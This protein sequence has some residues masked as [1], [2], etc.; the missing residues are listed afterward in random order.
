MGLCQ[1]LAGLVVIENQDSC[2]APSS[3]R[4]RALQN[5]SLSWFRAAHRCNVAR[6]RVLARLSPWI[7]QGPDGHPILKTQ[8]GVRMSV[9]GTFL[10]SE[11]RAGSAAVSSWRARPRLLRYFHVLISSLGRLPLS[12][13]FTG[14]PPG[15]P[16]LHI[17][18]LLVPVL[19]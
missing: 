16:R 9:A 14:P 18:L 1:S 19:S 12:A 8:H 10:L 6:P 11:R 13:V 17:G 3:F 4:R 15:P 5:C 7:P 2:S